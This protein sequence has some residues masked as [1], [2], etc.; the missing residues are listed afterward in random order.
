MRASGTAGALRVGYQWAADLGA[1]EMTPD[2]ISRV[3]F[4]L[5]STIVDR[6]DYWLHQ[7]PIDLVLALGTTEWLWRDVALVRGD[8]DA[9][10]VVLA[11]LPIV[12]ER[13]LVSG[14]EDRGG[15]GSWAASGR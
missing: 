2:P 3:A 15:E 10:S 14:R 6:H 5:R 1:W 13:V 8:D 9:I 4:V 7:A 12:S 11:E